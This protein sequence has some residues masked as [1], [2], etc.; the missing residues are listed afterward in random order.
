MPL[1][2]KGPPM[3]EML[4]FSFYI[5]ST[6]TYFIFRFVSEHCLQYAENYMYVY[7]TVSIH[8]YTVGNAEK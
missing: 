6:C 8:V 1:S 3:L 4:D 7:F 2:N 5:G